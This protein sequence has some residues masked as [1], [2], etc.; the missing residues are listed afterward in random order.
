M[1]LSKGRNVGH[2][3]NLTR[4]GDTLFADLRIRDEKEFQ[5][6]ARVCIGT[7]EDL[8]GKPR[9]TEFRLS[10]TDQHF[11]GFIHSKAKAAVPFLMVG[12]LRGH[13]VGT[14]TLEAIRMDFAK[15][16]AEGWLPPVVIQ[17]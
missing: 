10:A 14:D 11:Q 2:V 16:K 4:R 6:E 17:G 15:K 8:E 5:K 3:E 9:I 7:I 12:T 13:T 1:V